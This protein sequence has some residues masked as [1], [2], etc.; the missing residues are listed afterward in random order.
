VSRVR[1]RMSEGWRAAS[2]AARRMAATRSATIFLDGPE[3]KT[4]SACRP[5]NPRPAGDSGP[6]RAPASAVATAPPGERH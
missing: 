5:A 1:I 2:A 3:M 4:H 6:D